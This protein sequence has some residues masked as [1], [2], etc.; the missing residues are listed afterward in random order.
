MASIVNLTFFYPF[1]PNCPTSLD[2]FSEPVT[3]NPTIHRLISKKPLNLVDIADTTNEIESNSKKRDRSDSDSFFDTNECEL[4]KVYKNLK[5][6]EL[7]TFPSD[8]V[9]SAEIANEQSR[10]SK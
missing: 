1:C 9:F 8:V 5:S 10:R 4:V 2:L 7:F 6:T 3:K